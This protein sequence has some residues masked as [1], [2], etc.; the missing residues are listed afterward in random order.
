ME[1]NNTRI[2]TAESEG[3]LKVE[4]KGYNTM[5]NAFILVMVAG[6]IA[7]ILF[8]AVIT[9][10]TLAYSSG[11]KTD[12]YPLIHGVSL[13]Y[14]I[15]SFLIFARASV[16]TLFGKETLEIAPDYFGYKKTALVTLI[17]RRFKR[18]EIV[19]L[20]LADYF[21]PKDIIYAFQAELGITG[22]SYVLKTASDKIRF[23]ICLTSDELRE[24][25]KFYAFK[26][27][28]SR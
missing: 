16:W 26:A 17:D 19:E 20:K 27:L 22:R 9:A 3:I 8:I 4:I 11:S 24:L 5:L 7:G 14:I 15:I 1:N 23:G 12:F 6:F 13:F 10:A 28:V 2:N 21:E 25:E 18:D